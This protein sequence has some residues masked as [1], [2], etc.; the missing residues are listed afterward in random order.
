MNG[1]EHL[2]PEATLLSIFGSA[3][4]LEIV[5]D[6][7]KSNGIAMKKVD[8]AERVANLISQTTVHRPELHS[9]LLDDLD[10]LL[11]R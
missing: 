4:P 11:A 2:Y 7:A 6:E 8:L 5:G 9:K 3:A 10:R 1:I